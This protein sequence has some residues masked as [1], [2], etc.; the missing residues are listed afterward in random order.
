MAT[1][2]HN[3]WVNLF[4][5][6]RFLPTSFWADIPPPLYQHT[7]GNGLLHY[8]ITLNA[9]FSSPVIEFTV[10]SVV[11]IQGDGA[12]ATWEMA[13]FLEVSSLGL[14]LD[15]LLAWESQRHCKS[16]TL[17]TDLISTSKPT[18]YSCLFQLK[19]WYQTVLWA[20]FLQ[21]LSHLSSQV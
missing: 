21:S 2:S 13:A 17:W 5:S 16:Q 4:L 1:G 7:A 14:R 19:E 11:I 15:N 18:F 3:F 8:W 6:T 12:M 9:G 10:G 20:F